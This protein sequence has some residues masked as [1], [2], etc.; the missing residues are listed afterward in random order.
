[1]EEVPERI[2]RELVPRVIAV[3]FVGAIAFACSGSSFIGTETGAGTSGVGGSSSVGGKGG[4][5]SG[6]SSGSAGKG[7]G[8]A[9][10]GGT[11]Q[12][13]GGASG[14]NGGSGDT[15]G[16]NAG[17]AGGGS[18]GSGNASGE[19]GANA[20]GS[21]NASGDGG[22]GGGAGGGLGGIGGALGGIGGSGNQAGTAGE[23]GAE[24][25][26]PADCEMVSD[27]C[28]CAAQ[29]KGMP[30]LTCGLVCVTDACT[31]M[32]IERDEVTCAFGRCVIARSCDLS[33]VTC[34]AVQ[35][36]CPSGTIPSVDGSCFG[37]CLQPT[38]CSDVTN[39]ADCGSSDVCVR[40]SAQ[41]DS[42]GC[43]APSQGCQAGSYC[44]CL[45]ACMGSFSACSENEER[46][47]CSCLAC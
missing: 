9:G 12:A 37:P 33:R 35:P 46:V 26:S 15:G 18:A 25:E 11:G 41:L 44:D 30:P 8:G 32:Q 24:C 4:K 6:G 31:A 10:S 19:G 36:T 47:T 17:G 39:C 22:I 7:S 1:L 20:G 29:P 2:I 27:C 23:G 28:T 13:G 3:V 16:T 42:T 5:G 21:S 14:G 43:V 45:G 38:Q 40:H 34:E